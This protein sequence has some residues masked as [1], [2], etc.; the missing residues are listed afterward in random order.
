MK[1]DVEIDSSIRLTGDYMGRT[2]EIEYLADILNDP[3]ISVVCELMGG[4]IDAWTIMQECFHRG[5]HLI[6]YPVSKPSII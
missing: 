5:K 1:R 2:A 6:T 3:E 4:I